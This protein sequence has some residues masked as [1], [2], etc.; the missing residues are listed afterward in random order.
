M[1]WFVNIKNTGS[2][3]PYLSSTH[4][5]DLKSGPFNPAAQ[6]LPGEIVQGQHSSYH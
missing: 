1:L 6:D 3:N 5:A 2:Y 4:Y